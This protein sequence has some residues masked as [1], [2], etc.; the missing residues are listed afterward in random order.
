MKDPI[1]T[2]FNRKNKTLRSVLMTRSVLKLLE[3]NRNT[4]R[5]L[6]QQSSPPTAT[7]STTSRTDHQM[8]MAH[9]S[10]ERTIP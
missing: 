8:V 5:S 4:V 2:V 3:E 7:A 10:V 9:E 6:Q 1:T